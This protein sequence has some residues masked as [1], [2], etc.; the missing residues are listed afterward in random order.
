MRICRII[1]HIISLLCFVFAQQAQA[2]FSINITQTDT[3]L[4][5]G[6]SIPLNTVVQAVSQNSCFYPNFK[7]IANSN[8]DGIGSVFV[9]PNKNVYVS[10]N[11][12]GT[13]NFG[14]LIIPLLMI[15]IITVIL[16]LALTEHSIL[17]ACHNIFSRLMVLEVI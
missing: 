11:Y 12:S 14:N 5:V 8:I 7:N 10:A 9:D 13:L 16:Q 17:V 15:I 2:Q 6:Q 3:P 1:V 4:C